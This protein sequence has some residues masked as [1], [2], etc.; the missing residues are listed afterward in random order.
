MADLPGRGDFSIDAVAAAIAERLVES[1][2]GRL[3]DPVAERVA[4]RLLAGGEVDQTTSPLGPRRHIN[5]IRSGK[6][7][8]MQKGRRYVANRSDV[9]AFIANG[10]K[11][12]TGGPKHQLSNDPTDALA[13]E[14]GLLPEMEP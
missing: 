9:E 2:V 4:L 6:L 7:P 3:A 14:L 11:A 10:N 1:L 5:A 8:G 13:A 12:R